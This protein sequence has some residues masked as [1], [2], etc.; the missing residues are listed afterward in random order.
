MTNDMSLLRTMFLR[1]V[2]IGLATIAGGN[3]TRSTATPED[4]GRGKTQSGFKWT[5]KNVD[6]EP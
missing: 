1:F 4:V 6:G 2:R 5:G 3:S